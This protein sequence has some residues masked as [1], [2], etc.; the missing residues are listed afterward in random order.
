MMPETLQH[1]CKLQDK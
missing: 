1:T